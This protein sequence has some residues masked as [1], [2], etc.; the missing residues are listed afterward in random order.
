M[1]R[2]LLRTILI[3]LLINH[4]ITILH[5]SD[6]KRDY[7]LKKAMSLTVTEIDTASKLKLS[8]SYPDE[9]LNYLM[10]EKLDSMVNTWYIQNAFK[11]DSLGIALLP[12]S[13]KKS[14][15]DSV[16]IERLKDM[17]SFIDLSYNKTV[18]NFI[19][20]YTIKRREQVS[21]MLGLANYYFPIFEEMLDKY[22][23]P[24][25][26]KYM[27]IIE[28]AL[29]PKAL[30]RAG[31]SG[32]WQFMYGTAKMY[33]L[34]INSFVDERRDPI[35]A[36]EAAAKHLKHLY[37][38]YGDWHLV[39]AAYN[40]GAGNVNKAIR[41]SGG[42]RNYWDIYYRLPRETRGYVPAFIAAAYAM[43]YAKEH[44]LTAREPDFRI[45][46]DSVHVNSYLHFDQLT[47][48]LGIS[49]GEI[50]TLNPQYR[51]DIIPATAKK[52]YTLKLPVKHISQFIDLEKQVYAHNREKHF[53][54][55]QI[56][57]PKS[58]GYY[59]HNPVD[60]K[61]KDKVFYT[62]KSGDNVGFISSWFKVR[63]SDLRYWNN[64]SRNLIRVGQKLVVYV[65]TGKGE[66]F[67]KFNTMSFASKQRSVGKKAPTLAAKSNNTSSFVS[68]KY[69][70]YTVRRGDNL[71]SIAKKFPGI[72]NND[73][74]KANKLR[75]GKNIYPGQKLKIPQKA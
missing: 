11:Y 46:T 50:R 24:L 44:H 25:E 14:L 12:D 7:N 21:I 72:S 48:V 35:I 28:S 20:L 13:L 68:G 32:L 29:N 40:C 59:K 62:V 56:A 18:K 1:K 36:T 33:K 45:I 66:Y 30:S 16:Y 43:H 54:N 26:L 2:I 55:N 49:M 34:E 69:K 41:R 5:A 64:I 15:P 10:A 42:A 23:M 4:T 63:A 73:I 74:I 53:P 6:S 22:E 61:G 9:D 31:A 70:Y 75:N 67:K 19:A 57:T 17:N 58:G 39:I 3:T 8:Y 38:I 71:W 51:H 37:K 52:S 60:I 47:D 27:A 65:P